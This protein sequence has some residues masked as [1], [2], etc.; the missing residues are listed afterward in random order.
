[1]I[2]LYCSVVTDC[3]DYLLFLSGKHFTYWLFLFFSILAGLSIVA[4]DSSKRVEKMNAAGAGK[5]I[6]IN[7][8]D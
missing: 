6:N 4:P 3:R 7:F 8:L 1:M 5:L 2:R